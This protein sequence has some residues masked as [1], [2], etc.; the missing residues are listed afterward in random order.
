MWTGLWGV[1]LSTG[2]FTL[3]ARKERYRAAT[4]RES[5]PVWFRLRRVRELAWA[6]GPPRLMR[7]QVGRT[8]WTRSLALDHISSWPTWASAWDQ[9]VRPTWRLQRSRRLSRFRLTAPG[10]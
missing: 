1:L 10:A 5:V 7:R 9:G 6:C 4:V 2:R 3:A 8:P